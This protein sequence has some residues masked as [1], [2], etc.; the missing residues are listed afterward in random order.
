MHSVGCCRGV[1]HVIVAEDFTFAPASAMA[2]DVTGFGFPTRDAVDALTFSSLGHFR[3]RAGRGL[4]LWLVP[5]P[6]TLGNIYAAPK[7]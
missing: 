2:D 1:E 5:L 6:H 3:W 7:S 4:F